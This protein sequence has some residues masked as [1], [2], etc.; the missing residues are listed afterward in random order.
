[1]ESILCERTDRVMALRAEYLQGNFLPACGTT[2]GVLLFFLAAACMTAR[3]PARSG[4]FF[5][6]LFPLAS[7]VRMTRASRAGAAEGRGLGPGAWPFFLFDARCYERRREKVAFRG[8]ALVQQRFRL[9]GV[10]RPGRGLDKG[11]P[12]SEISSHPTPAAMSA[13]AS[14]LPR[15]CFD[16]NC[17]TSWRA[18][19]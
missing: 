6:H 2:G 8:R 3:R 17:V 10:A 1:M 5:R 16:T 11:V 4:R 14:G 9:N 13:K 7:S 15:T 12:A 18:W 19:S